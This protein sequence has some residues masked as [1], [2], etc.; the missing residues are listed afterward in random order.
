M[1]LVWGV[2]TFYY[3]SE[4]DIDKTLVEIEKYLVDTGNLKKGDVFINTASMPQHWE[5]HTN[6]MKV[7]V[8]E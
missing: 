1:C 2:K 4:E 8:V 5:G 7:Q 6:M 3:D